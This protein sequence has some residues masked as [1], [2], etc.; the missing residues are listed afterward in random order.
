[1][2]EER[3]SPLQSTVQAC[4]ERESALFL[5]HKTMEVQYKG[6]RGMQVSLS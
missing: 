5:R 3:K 1:M 2:A 6:D 4:G